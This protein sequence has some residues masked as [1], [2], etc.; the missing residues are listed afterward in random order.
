MQRAATSIVLI[1]GQLALLCA[2]PLYLCTSADGSQRIEW[3][4]CD[5]ADSGHSHGLPRT[6]SPAVDFAHEQRVGEP[7]C[8]CEHEPLTEGT[9][10]VSR[11]EHDARGPL[12]APFVGT[13]EPMTVSIAAQ[14]SAVVSPSGHTPLVDRLSIC[15]RC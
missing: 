8:Q 6:H 15:L 5:C 10:A 3:G 12:L 11:S 1:V 13:W 14:V 9:Q 7:P 4:Q 2:A